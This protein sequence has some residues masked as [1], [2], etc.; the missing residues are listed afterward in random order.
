[1]IE[2][3]ITG[4]IVSPLLGM[5]LGLGS[6][7]VFRLLFAGLAIGALAGVPVGLFKF[8]TG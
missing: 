7:D 5:A 6:K 2:G 1:M 4:V 3:G 8:L